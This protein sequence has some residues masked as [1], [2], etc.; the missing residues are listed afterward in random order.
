M[1]QNYELLA[2]VGGFPQLQAAISAGAT[3][4]YLGLKELNMRATGK[5]FTLKELKKA[6]QNGKSEYD[7]I[8][9][10]YLGSS[11]K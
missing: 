9:E 8:L 6:D 5:N 11:N 3:A 10:F 4:V 1:K 7:R 2:P